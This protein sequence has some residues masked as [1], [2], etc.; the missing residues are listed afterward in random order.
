MRHICHLSP[1]QCDSTTLSMMRW[2]TF[3]HPLNLS[4]LL[5]FWTDNC[6]RNDI[7]R[8]LRLVLERTCSSY[9]IFLGTPVSSSKEA[10]W[11]MTDGSRK[12][13]QESASRCQ[14]YKWGHQNQPPSW[15]VNWLQTWVNE[16]SWHH[17]KSNCPAE[18]NPN[19]Q[20]QTVR[21]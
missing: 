4:S 2:S 9:F 20:P 18:P 14:S 11:R 16:P 6:S 3:P 19:S 5:T 21:K 12:P 7:M 17:L 10:Y 13:S 8:L 1:L 15:P